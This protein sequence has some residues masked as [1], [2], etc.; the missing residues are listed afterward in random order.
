MNKQYS[1]IAYYM[2]SLNIYIFF[3]IIKSSMNKKKNKCNG[4]KLTNKHQCRCDNEFYADKQ[5]C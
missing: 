2:H 4:K 5:D 1:E 3:I